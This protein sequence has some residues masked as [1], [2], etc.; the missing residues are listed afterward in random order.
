MCAVPHSPL[1]GAAIACILTGQVVVTHHDHALLIVSVGAYVPGTIY[2]NISV[3][4]GE[5]TGAPVHRSSVST[6]NHAFGV[7][8][9]VAINA[10]YHVVG[11]T[12]REKSPHT[13]VSH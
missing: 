2:V 7:N 4:A 6:E 9:H 13:G 3:V 11:E 5:L 8:I 10:T 12:D 1:I